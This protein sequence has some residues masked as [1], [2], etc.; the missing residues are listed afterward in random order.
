MMIDDGWCEKIGHAAQL[1]KD[2]GAARV[3]G[4]F[5]RRART[6]NRDLD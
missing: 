2:G 1:E 3:D 5:C 4:D 6:P